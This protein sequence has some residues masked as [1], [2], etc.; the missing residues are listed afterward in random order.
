MALEEVE[1]V[2]FNLETVA[3]SMKFSL[4]LSRIVIGL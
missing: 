4:V 3:M 2:T 1:L